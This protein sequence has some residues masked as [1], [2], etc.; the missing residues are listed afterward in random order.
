VTAK[1][2]RGII[3]PLALLIT[4]RDKGEEPT[5]VDAWL[6]GIRALGVENELLDQFK[7]AMKKLVTRVKPQSGIKI[8][9]ASIYCNYKERETQTRADLLAS[10]W[11]QLLQDERPLDKNAIGLY[12][13][14]HN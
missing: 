12:E 5:T 1:T 9:I 3:S 10:L 14:H 7:V 4:L 6:T 2:V 13:V 8:G 11:M